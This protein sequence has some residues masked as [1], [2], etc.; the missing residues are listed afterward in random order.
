MQNSINPNQKDRK[1]APKPWRGLRH[2]SRLKFVEESFGPF[3][4]GSKKEGSKNPKLKKIEYAPLGVM[5]KLRHALGREG[6]KN[7]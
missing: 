6:L 7:L 3:R 1:G 4:M 2:I 5:R